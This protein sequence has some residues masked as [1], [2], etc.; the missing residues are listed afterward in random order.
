MKTI[1]ITIAKDGTYTMKAGEGFAGS[2]CLQQ[3]QTIEQLIGVG[4]NVIADGKTDD[5]FKAGNPVDT[6]NEIRS[7]L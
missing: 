7:L 6:M 1:K 3:T 4:A 5:Y 2:N